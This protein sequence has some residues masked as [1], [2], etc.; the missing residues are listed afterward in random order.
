MRDKMEPFETQ[1]LT[2]LKERLEKEGID[3]SQLVFEEADP[4]GEV[5]Y[6]F[7]E[8]HIT[9]FENDKEA[10]FGW[11][12]DYITVDRMD[13]DNP[14]ERVA[15][16]VDRFLYYYTHPNARRFWVSRFWH[17]IKEAMGGGNAK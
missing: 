16:F 10:H 6:K 14:D 7:G 4:S 8:M 12:G 2:A 17:W 13:S 1:C 15:M 3:T 9:I 5:S 11:K